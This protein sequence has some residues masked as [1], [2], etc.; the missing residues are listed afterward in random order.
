M[1]LFN[2]RRSSFN[3]KEYRRNYFNSTDFPGLVIPSETNAWVSVSGFRENGHAF[4]G[5]KAQRS[6]ITAALRAA[7]DSNTE[8]REEQREFNLIA[9]PGYPE[10][11]SNMV[12]LN[13]DRKQTAFIVG[14]SPMRIASEGTSLTNWLQNTNL[15]GVDSENALVT[16]DPYVGVWYP[17]VLGNDL[18]GNQVALPSSYGVLRMMIRNDQLSYPWF[19]PAGVRRGIID[20]ASRLGYLTNTGEFVT[21]GVRQGVRDTL[22]ENR[23]NPLMQTPQTGIVAFGQKTRSA[24]SSALDRVNIAR[25]IAYMRSQLDKVVRQFLFEPNDKITRDEVKGVIDSFCNDLIAKRALYDYLVVCDD[26]NNTPDRIDRNEL[27]IDIAIEP[28]KAIEFI[29]IPIRI[30]NTGEIAG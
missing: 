17:A 24:S 12:Q 25:L 13:N 28:V 7:L 3:V 6:V 30:K 14:D 2:T 20:N 29:Y 18:N 11:I 8:I 22:Y 19:A 15:E 26:T 4:F 21:I 5:R 1:L 27:Y 10:L 9:C 16:S 23:V